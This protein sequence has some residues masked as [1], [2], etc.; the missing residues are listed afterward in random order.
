MSVAVVP[1]DTFQLL[2]HLTSI[3]LVNLMHVEGLRHCV[4][5]RYLVYIKAGFAQFGPQPGST[6]LPTT[7]LPPVPPSEA[8]PDCQKNLCDH[9]S[10]YVVVG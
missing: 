4:Q 3:L 5:L 6:G 7:A 1:F 10:C 9:V 2:Q 8:I